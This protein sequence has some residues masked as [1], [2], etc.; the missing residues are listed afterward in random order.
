MSEIIESLSLILV[1]M[2]LLT[3]S[4]LLISLEEIEIGGLKRSSKIF[5]TVTCQL[6]IRA[7]I[8]IQNY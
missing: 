2:A 4:T 8:V 5:A 1:T 6:N 3:Y 7:L